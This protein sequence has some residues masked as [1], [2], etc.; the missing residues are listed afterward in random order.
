[1]TGVEW[2]HNTRMVEPLHCSPETITTLLSGYTPI[3]NKKLKSRNFNFL[4]V[5]KQELLL[6][7]N[8]KYTSHFLRNSAG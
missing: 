7:F 5:K 8:S 6:N 4:K 2:I 1:M 3:Q